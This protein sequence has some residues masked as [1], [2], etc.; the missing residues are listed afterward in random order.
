MNS[1]PDTVRKIFNAG[2]LYADRQFYPNP[3][4]NTSTW[5]VISLSDGI[6]SATVGFYRTDFSL[7]LPTGYDFP[8]VLNVGG[9][10]VNDMSQGFR[11]NIWVNGWKVGRFISYLG[12]QTAFVVPPGI[13][14]LGGT[15]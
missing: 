3:G 4:Y 15:K 7:A 14:N 13:L 9:L 10:A 2:G 5:P 12:P 6:H 1:F 8:V 11:S